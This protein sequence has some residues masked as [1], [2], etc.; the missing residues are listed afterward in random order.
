VSARTREGGK[1][2]G[3]ERKDQAGSLRRGGDGVLFC[4]CESRAGQGRP[5]GARTR[6]GGKGRREEVKDQGEGGAGGAV[7]RACERRAGD[8]WAGN[9]EHS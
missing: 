5:V 9:P 6:E 7:P 8:R 3:D 1:R 2:R 4:K